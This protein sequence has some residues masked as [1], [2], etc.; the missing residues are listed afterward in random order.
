MAC[1]YKLQDGPSRPSIFSRYFVQKLVREGRSSKVAPTI[2]T[3][4]HRAVFLIADNTLD[5]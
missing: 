4:G 1:L 5:Q 3:E 2:L